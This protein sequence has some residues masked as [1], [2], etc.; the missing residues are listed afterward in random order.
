[1]PIRV[2]C[3]ACGCRGDVEA[4]MVDDD[5]KRLAAQF[6][7]LEPALARA[8]LAYLRLFRPPA[9]EL[10]MARAARIVDELVALVQTGTVCRD[11]RTGQRRP[12]PPAVWTAALE[13]ML[14][15]PPSEPLTNHNYLRAVA[16]GAAG[17]YSQRSGHAV[18]PTTTVRHTGI[19]PERPRD[20]LWEQQEFLRTQLTYGQIT[21]E[22]HDRQLAALRG[23]AP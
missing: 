15:A 5:A 20:P 10:R 11:E 22:E 18:A 2:T 4:F 14:A 7:G 9:R 6:A 16:W 17:E 13:Q 21:R 8:A 1:M 12:A 3:P 19:S 23:Q